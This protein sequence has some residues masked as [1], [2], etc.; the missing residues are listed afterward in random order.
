MRLTRVVHTLSAL[1]LCLGFSAGIVACKKDEPAPAKKEEAAKKDEKK[2][3][4]KK[5]DKADKPKKAKATKEAPKKVEVPADKKPNPVPA[6]WERMEN[7]SMGFAFS[8][9]KGS[10]DHQDKKGGKD[11]FVAVTPK[12]HEILVY[13]AAWK[14]AS[15]T[16]DD[17]LKEASAMMVAEGEKDVAQ[18]D[19]TA[20][21]DDY[22]IATVTSTGDKGEKTKCRALVAI[23]VTDNYVML[24]CTEEKDF[25]A[26]E[27]TV[28]EIWGSF[29]MYSGGASGASK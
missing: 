20:L 22:T 18:T 12:P 1:A 5:D 17:L 10:K 21:N 11:I 19:V 6:D 3:E 27:T 29:E 9:P 13:V 16:K 2:D 15:K 7:A 24:V 25:K 8:V 23:D 26:N 28:D 14:D 4:A